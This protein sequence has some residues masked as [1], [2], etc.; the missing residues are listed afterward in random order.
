MDTN[1]NAT[2]ECNHA[3]EVG[4]EITDKVKM[5]FGKHIH[6][7]LLCSITMETALYLSTIY[8]RVVSENI[9]PSIGSEKLLSPWRQP[10]TFA[11][12]MIG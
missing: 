11:Q 6:Q 9:S 5:E 8:D 10:S 3:G 2:K 4:W 12:Y 1:T 7:K